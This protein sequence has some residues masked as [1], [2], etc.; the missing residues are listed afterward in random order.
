MTKGIFKKLVFVYILL[1]LSLVSYSQSQ[2]VYKNFV[3]NNY[4]RWVGVNPSKFKSYE[5]RVI[6]LN[7]YYN[8]YV[9]AMLSGDAQTADSALT[10][11]NR[12]SNTSYTSL[13]YSLDTAGIASDVLNLSVQTN[14]SLISYSVQINEID[15]SVTVFITL[16]EDTLAQYPLTQAM[17]DSL[18][19]LDS[20]LRKYVDDTIYYYT[21]STVFL[22]SVGDLR[23][24]ISNNISQSIL[25]DTLSYYWT[26]NRSND[27]IIAKI[28]RIESLTETDPIYAAD[29]ADI[30]HF[31]DIPDID[32]VSDSSWTEANADTLR[33]FN[34]EFTDDNGNILFMDGVDTSKIGLDS[35]RIEFI[36]FNDQS[37]DINGYGH[38]QINANTSTGKIINTLNNGT[39]AVLDGADT[40]FRVKESGLNILDTIVKVV[41]PDTLV[42]KEYV[43]NLVSESVVGSTTNGYIPY[44]SSGIFVNSPFETN[45]ENIDVHIS[46]NGWMSFYNYFEDALYTG[47]FLTSSGVRHE[48]YEDSTR[49]SFSANSIVYQNYRNLNGY[50]KSWE[51]RFY[52]DS[53]KISRY[54]DYGSPIEDR[55]IKFDSSF[56]N[57]YKPTNISG[58]VSMYGDFTKNDSSLYQIIEE[59]A[60]TGDQDLS[61]YIQYIDTTGVD[62]KIPTVTDLD[63]TFQAAKD[64]ADN[65]VG[66]PAEYDTIGIVTDVDLTGGGWTTISTGQSTVIPKVISIQDTLYNEYEGSFELKYS[67]STN[68]Y[69]NIYSATSYDS[70]TIYWIKD[71]AGVSA[72]GSGEVT[73]SSTLIPGQIVLATGANTIGGSSNLTWNDTVLSISSGIG[74]YNLFI[75]D[76][77][78][79]SNLQTN[80]YY[81][82]SVG[83]NALNKLYV[84]SRN[85]AIGALSLNFLENGSNN[86]GIGAYSLYNNSS[87]DNTATGTYS[88]QANINGTRNTAIGSSSLN[89][90]TSG[91]YNISNGFFCLGHNTT[92]S[93]NIGIGYYAGLYNI[94]QNN[95]LYINSYGNRTNLLGDTT[96]SI[97]Y[98]IQAATTANQKLYFNSNVN[99]SNNL[100]V[101]GMFK[102]TQLSASLTDGSPTDAEIDSA[103]GTTPATVGAGY[104]V[105]IKD[106]DGTGLL[107][108]VES[109]GTNWYYIVMTQAL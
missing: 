3:Y 79:E 44:D 20:T 103:T 82:T 88:L 75:G 53:L 31:A 104:Q 34:I 63:T 27:S 35:T 74:L 78:T 52:E 80:T 65:V 5:P 9:Q 38:V 24:S 81:N 54:T 76:S 51:M 6:Q 13:P 7:S 25:D 60:G 16:I 101:N 8:I 92:G 56:V 61:G 106:S 99:V 42:N 70:L 29:S 21:L 40:L 77:S 11:Y 39:F 67:F 93:N 14:D 87:D 26:G 41:M 66:S 4:T 72:G 10:E 57:I 2:D 28:N 37:I 105:T 18:L 50:L 85:T 73:V 17:V 91:S 84:G 62:K 22:D 95:R 68:W 69:I 45:G 12:I 97:I 102:N 36:G 1:L 89:S 32:F 71:D 33:T 100:T 55:I 19:D 59:H 86:T 58:N 30:V 64:Y 96:R 83:V 90:N 109:D 108:K 47:L 43:D 49:I 48:N 107:Y 15:S 94:A 23:T 46:G 98:G